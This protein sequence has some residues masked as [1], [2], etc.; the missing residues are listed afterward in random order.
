MSAADF[1]DVGLISFSLKNVLKTLLRYFMRILS[2]SR[3]SKL[4]RYNWWICPTLNSETI[5]PTSVLMSYIWVHFAI[6]HSIYCYLDFKLRY[7]KNLKLLSIRVKQLFDPIVCENKKRRVF[8]LLK[9]FSWETDLW[10]T[11]GDLTV[12]KHQIGKGNL[13]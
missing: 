12:K 13:Y 3:H 6:G 9:A 1:Y 2:I 7:L 10:L 5:L 4:R 11:L 8:A